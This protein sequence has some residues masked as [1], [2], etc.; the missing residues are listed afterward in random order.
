MRR[1]R[2]RNQ[3]KDLLGWSTKVS[4]QIVIF[5]VVYICMCINVMLCT[6]NHIQYSYPQVVPQPVTSYLLCTFAISFKHCTHTEP[7]YDN[8]VE[9]ANVSY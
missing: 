5:K 1:K 6:H 3:R 2:K 4:V 7:L 8:R 9:D